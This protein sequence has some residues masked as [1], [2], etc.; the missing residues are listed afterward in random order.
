MARVR[1]L[2]PVYLRLLAHRALV[3]PSSSALAE[4]KNASAMLLL[5]MRRRDDSS[6]L[7]ACSS[8][9]RAS[10]A[11]FRSGAI[12]NAGSLPFDAEDLTLR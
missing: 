11:L 9:A 6:T 5:Q 2:L 10:T 12:P 8:A 7:A 1:R 4:R 3:P